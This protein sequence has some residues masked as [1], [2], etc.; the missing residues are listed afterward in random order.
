MTTLGF[1]V[2]SNETHTYNWQN[3]EFTICINTFVCC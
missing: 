3:I 1:A 2:Q